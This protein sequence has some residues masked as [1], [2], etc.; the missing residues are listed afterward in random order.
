MENEL[1]RHVKNTQEDLLLARVRGQSTAQRVPNLRSVSC[2]YDP[3]ARMNPVSRTSY[4]PL[5]PLTI[6]TPKVNTQFW[7]L[8]MQML[9]C[10]SV[11]QDRLKAG[12]NRAVCGGRA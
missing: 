10:F 5:A 7:V 11:V 8:E 3:P 9:V 1:Y 2:T 4:A 6:T 12:A